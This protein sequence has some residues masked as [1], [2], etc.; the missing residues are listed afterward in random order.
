MYFYRTKSDDNITNNTADCV[1][2]IVFIVDEIT[3]TMIR[4]DIRTLVRL[5]GY[6]KFE[7]THYTHCI[8]D[9]YFVN[10]LLNGFTTQC[11]IADK[12][13]YE[14]VYKNGLPIGRERTDM[15]IVTYVENKDNYQYAYSAEM[16]RLRNNKIESSYYL[17]SVHYTEYVRCYGKYLTN[18]QSMYSIVLFRHELVMREIME[19]GYVKIGNVLYTIDGNSL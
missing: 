5:D 12:T 11:N 4:L 7:I 16:F 10:G 18:I 3:Q 2:G 15:H 1:N 17:D 14:V 13:T 6:K 19:D 9:G 8:I